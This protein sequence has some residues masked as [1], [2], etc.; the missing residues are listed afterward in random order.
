MLKPGNVKNIYPLTERKSVRVADNPGKP[1]L[2]DRVREALRSRHYS[3]RI[4]QSSYM[5]Y[6]PAFVRNPFTK[7]GL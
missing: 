6:V 2:L 3:P 5:P 4:D 7:R 1:K